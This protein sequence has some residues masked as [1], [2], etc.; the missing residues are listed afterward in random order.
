MTIKSAINKAKKII[1]VSRSTAKDLQQVLHVPSN[2][3]QVIYEGVNAQFGPVDDVHSLLSTLHKYG[4]EKSFL[5]YT[6]V[7]RDHKNLKGLIQAFR[8]LIKKEHNLQLVITGKKNNIYAEEI[9]DLTADLVEEKKVIF[10]DLVNEE[11]LVHLIDSA[12]VYVFPSFY[13]GFGL[14]P[15]EAMQCHTPVAASNTSCIPEI[16]GDNAVYFNPHNPED[17]AQAIEKLLTDKDLYFRL[18]QS[19]ADHVKKFSWSKMS[20]QIHDLYLDVIKDL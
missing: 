17:M 2:K 14:P 8:I 4:I 3:M 11:E 10:T 5:L 7:W 19:G 1:A 20:R 16:C 9:F 13:E 6:G 18:Q 12:Q 15:L